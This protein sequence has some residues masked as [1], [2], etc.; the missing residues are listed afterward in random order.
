M[1]FGLFFLF[2]FGCSSND[3]R[4]DKVYEQ[5]S[6]VINYNEDS[7]KIISFGFMNKKGQTGEWFFLDDSQ[8]VEK[9]QNF[10]NGILDA[11]WMSIAIVQKNFF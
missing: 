9:I 7:T 5:D 10:T 8:K 1:I 4:I 11:K 3:I 6:L 2:H